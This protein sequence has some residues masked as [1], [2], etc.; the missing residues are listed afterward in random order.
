MT[1][2]DILPSKLLCKEVIRKEKIINGIIIPE[3]AGKDPNISGTVSLIGANVLT[4]LSPARPILLNDK[5][6]F[7]PHAPQR[8]RIDGDDFLL[9]DCKDILFYTTPEP[10]IT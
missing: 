4:L 7:N 9:I 10:Q 2:G 3:T 6:L 8:V 5:V 1:S